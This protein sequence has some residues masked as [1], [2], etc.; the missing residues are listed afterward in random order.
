MKVLIDGRPLVGER[1]G[2]GVHTAEIAR[3]LPE[4]P[5]IAS[6]AEIIDR[7]GIEHCRFRVDRALN[8]IVWQQ[9]VLPRIADADVLWGPHG[10]IPLRERLPSVVTIHDFTSITMPGRHRLKTIASYNLFIARSLERAQRVA[11]VSRAVAD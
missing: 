4:A 8:G 5:L 1:T 10:T 7:S 6:H 11:A 9:F 3:R 2:I